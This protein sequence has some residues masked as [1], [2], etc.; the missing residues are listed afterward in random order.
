[1]QRAEAVR[2]Y[3]IMR[4]VD[5]DRL[6]ARGYGPDKPISGNGNASG[7][8]MNRRVELKRID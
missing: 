8:A 5:A 6:V 2:A 7:R 1:V 4:G 3:L